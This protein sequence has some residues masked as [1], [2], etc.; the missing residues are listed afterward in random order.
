[1]NDTTIHKIIS[2]LNRRTFKGLIYTREL[3]NTVDFAKLWMQKPR[4]NDEPFNVEGPSEPFRFYFIKTVDGVYAGAVFDMN[5]DL[6]AYVMPKFRGNGLLSQALINHILPHL[7]LSRDELRITIDRGFLGA[8]GFASSEKVALRVG[9][10]KCRQINEKHIYTLSAEKY[11]REAYFDGR[12]NVPT[13][14]RVHAIRKQINFAARSLMVA[15]TE[16]EMKI[17]ICD[18][19]MELKELVSTIERQLS[20]LDG[21]LTRLR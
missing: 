15:Q 18:Y 4:P 10:L 7:F 16:L 9:F 20:S 2:A 14:E 8:K 5:T 13:Q 12:D 3:D 11:E 1:M 19:T 21:A 6:H 17:G